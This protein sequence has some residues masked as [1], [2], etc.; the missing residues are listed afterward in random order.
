MAKN[1]EILTAAEIASFTRKL[2]ATIAAAQRAIELTQLLSKLKGPLGSTASAPRAASAE[3]A[4]GG[5]RKAR[6]KRQPGMAVE[7]VL[8]A[9]KGAKDGLSLAALATKVGEKN[10][11]RVGAA[12]RKLRDEKKVVVKGDRRMAKWYAA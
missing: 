2:N 4:E 7:P 1:A 5:G 8:A 3:R 12:L 11:D 10:K 6:R 9:L